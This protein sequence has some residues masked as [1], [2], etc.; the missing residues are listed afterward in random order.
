[1]THLKSQW[2]ILKE[3]LFLIYFCHLPVLEKW[4]VGS[5]QTARSLDKY[6]DE[7]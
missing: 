4:I 6:T 3:G 7:H 2:N 5:S 1:M